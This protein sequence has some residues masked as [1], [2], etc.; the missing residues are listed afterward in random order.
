M[1]ISTVEFC[2]IARKHGPEL[3]LVP[4]P[5]CVG[6]LSITC[7]SEVNDGAV[8]LLVVPVPLVEHAVDPFGA[9]RLAARVSTLNAGFAARIRGF[10]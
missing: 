10:G 5:V 8:C 3:L 7:D 4:P 1:T 9:P 6:I 2:H